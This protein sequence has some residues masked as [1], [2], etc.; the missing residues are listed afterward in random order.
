MAFVYHQ[1][2]CDES[3]KYHNP[4]DPLISFAGVSATADRLEAFDRSW[5]SLLLSYELESIHMER[6]SRLVEE[7]GYRFRKNQTIE[8]RTE[9][10]YPFADLVN[11]HLEAGFFQA[12]SI[13]GYSFLS[14]KA[15][16][17]LGG[18]DDPYFLA[19]VRGL[20]AIIDH[21]GEDDR[22]GIIVDDDINTAWDCYRHYRM[23][24]K[25]DWR[26]QKKAVSLSF[27]NDKHFPALQA[28]DMLAFL[29]KHEAAERFTGASNI[30]KKLFN[31]LTTHPEPAY[32][33]MRW[34]GMFA[35]E[36]ELLDFAI[37]MD[38]YAQR[39][40]KEE[41]LS[42]VQQ[43]R[44]ND[45]GAAKGSPQRNPTKTGRGKRAK[46]KAQGGKGQ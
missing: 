26:I 27:A 31:R 40:A 5:R 10:L 42:R 11:K 2:F 8:E 9:L 16:K 4:N 20:Q 33:I 41:Q 35:H 15:K 19:F 22:V 7:H 39:K 30:W 24:A 29:T 46:A 32:G 14:V 45:G 21:I 43:V 37:E 17:L 12:W 1:I 28:A 3:G 25:A 34:F 13:T 38:E 36:K 23:V 44:P 6:I 18:S